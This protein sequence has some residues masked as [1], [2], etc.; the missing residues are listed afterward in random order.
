MNR[1]LSVHSFSTRNSMSSHVNL[2]RRS[3]SMMSKLIWCVALKVNDRNVPVNWMKIPVCMNTFLC[4]PKYS[5][6]FTFRYIDNPHT[7]TQRERTRKCIIQLW[8]MCLKIW[9]SKIVTWFSKNNNDM[10]STQNNLFLLLSLSFSCSLLYWFLLTQF[11]PI[12]PIFLPYFFLNHSPQYIVWG[13]GVCNMIKLIVTLIKLFLFCSLSL[14]IR[15]SWVVKKVT[16]L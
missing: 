2:A 7:Y 6:I 11:P 10:R 9:Q 8:V 5:K 16:F 12:R 1:I 3:K 13:G 4:V 15:L 14:M